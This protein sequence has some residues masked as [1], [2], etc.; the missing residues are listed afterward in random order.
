MGIF[1]KTIFPNGAA[2]AD[3]RLKEGDE[4]LEVNGESLQ[5]LTHQQAIQTF[6]QLKKGV[7]T[8]TV[9]TRLR[10]PSLTPCPTPTLLSRSS[11][12]NSNASGGTPT[13]LPPTFDEPPEARKGPP[14]PG[15]K[16]RIIM[17]VTLNKEPGVG[18]GIGACCLTL[19]NSTPAIY[20]HSLAPGSVAK[21]DGRLSRGDQVLEVDSVSLRHAALS[22][23]YAILSECGPGPVSLIVSRHPNPKVSEQEM[24]E[25]IARSTHRD[26][27]SKDGHSSYTLGL[28]SK[29]PSPTAKAKQGD[30]TSLSW[31]MKRFLEPASRQGSLS[32]EAELSQ[33]FSQEV[34]RHSSLSETPLMGSSDDDM[35]HNQSC[36]TSSDDTP[37][38][39]HGCG[40]GDV[41]C[42]SG[43]LIPSVVSPGSSSVRSP[44]LR[45]RRV[46]CY[47][48]EVS[49]HDDDS[50]VH[51]VTGAGTASRVLADS[52]IVIATSSVEVDE[53]SEGPTTPPY[54]SSLESEEGLGSESPFM[55]IRHS[56]SHQLP[57]AGGGGSSPTTG[58]SNLGLTKDPQ[59][60]VEPRRSPK[61]EHKAVTRVKSMMSI[62]SPPNLPQQSQNQRPKGEESPSC[63]AQGPQLEGGS[64]RPTGLPDSTPPGLCKKGEDCG[65]SPGVCSMDR[66]VLTRREDESFGLDLEIKSS[67][68]KVV[69]TGMRP[70]G[71]ADRESQGRMCVGDE[72]VSIG[73]TPVCS[74]SYHNICEL[75]HNLPITL[76]LQ[77]KRPVS[78]VDRLSSL[79]MSM[80]SCDV[81]GPSRLDQSR[82]PQGAN[83]VASNLG[84]PASSVTTPNP[85]S[86][87]PSNHN[88][89]S[90]IPVTY[91]D[92]IL[93]ELSSSDVQ[94]ALST[95]APKT[96][97]EAQ[98][99]ACA[100][101]VES[102]DLPLT[103]KENSTSQPLPTRP[104]QL[105]IS[106]LDTGNKGCLL[107]LGKTFLNNYSRNFS[108]NLTDEGTNAFLNGVG[109][110]PVPSNLRCNMYNMVEDSDS[111]SEDTITD[112]SHSAATNNQSTQPQDSEEEEV[113]I[114]YNETQSPN[115]LSPH[116]LSLM[117]DVPLS[118]QP[119]ICGSETNNSTK[120]TGP[121]DVI[122][123]SASSPASS[124]AT[125][126]QHNKDWSVSTTAQLD[127]NPSCSQSLPGD[128]SSGA[129]LAVASCHVAFSSEEAD[130][131]SVGIACV[132]VGANPVCDKV[133]SSIAKPGQPCVSVCSTPV[134][135]ASQ[136][137]LP[138]SQERMDRFSALPCMAVGKISNDSQSQT[139]SHSIGTVEA[140]SLTHSNGRLGVS[141][142]SLSSVTTKD[143]EGE[144]VSSKSHVPFGPKTAP[145][146]TS[147]RLR[148]ND[149]IQKTS[150]TAP[151]LKG[152]SIKSKNQEQQL[153]PKTIRAESPSVIRKAKS[154]NSLL[155]S[156]K[157]QAKKS[158][159]AAVSSSRSSKELP[160]SGKQLEW[161]RMSSNGLNLSPKPGG[162][163]QD[164]SYTSTT[165]VSDAKTKPE[166]HSTEEKQATSAVAMPKEHPEPALTTQRTFIEVRLSTSST[167]S[168]PVLTRKETAYSKDYSITH[169]NHTPDIMSHKDQLNASSSGTSLRPGTPAPPGFPGNPEKGNNRARDSAVISIEPLAMGNALTNV[170]YKNSSL[171]DIG[172]E[173]LKA[174]NSKLKAMERRSFSTD[175]CIPTDPKSFSV[176]QRIKSFENL[177]SFDKP[178]L[179]SVEIQ[180][181]AQSYALT[182]AAKPPLN[183]RLSSYV[184]GSVNS[185]D[186]RSLRRS[187][188]SCVDN[189]DPTLTPLS[190]QL[191]KSPS[192]LTLTNFDLLTQ[193]CS[194]NKPP[195]DQTQNKLADREI[196][197]II[198]PGDAPITP[199]TPP[200]LRCKQARGHAHL[201]RSRLRELRALSMPDLDKLCTHDFSSDPGSNATFKTELEIYPT[202]HTEAVKTGDGST[203]AT[204]TGVLSSNASHDD[205]RACLGPIEGKTSQQEAD[206]CNWSISLAVLAGS[207]VE[208]SK[209][210]AVLAS[211]TTKTDVLALIQEA[212]A[213]SEVKDDAYFVVLSKEEGS[214]LGFSIAGGVDLEQK[215][216][217]V[218]RVFSKGVASLEGTI[219]RGDSILSIN[220]VS[221]EGTTHGEALSCLHKSRLSTQALVVIRRGKDGEGQTSP[222]HLTM[223]HRTGRSYSVGCRENVSETD[224][225]AV[226]VGPDGALRVELLKTSAGLGFSLE[227]GK[228]SA[229]GDR[230]L[231]VK[232]VFKG[233]AAELSRVV[234]VGDEVLEV[235]GRSLQGLMHYDAWNIIKTASEGPV[236]LVIRKPRTSV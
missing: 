188:S 134:G 221:L 45:Q 167:S 169:I 4:I 230:P 206:G 26:S 122:Q 83:G 64:G 174:N 214:G 35:L 210:Q 227:G 31:T 112:D 172:V 124:A 203:S 138:Q 135:L 91:I 148:V 195:I 217:I 162:L 211:L 60:P 67:P 33:Y 50:A 145:P 89:S 97:S 70:G 102:K 233:G 57:R 69:I 232:R 119:P 81:T 213:L 152:L 179:K 151:K 181:F 139:P 63:A 224:R 163:A 106:V 160:A 77:V 235:N 43:P 23:A 72:I 198:P 125:L 191:G 209:L 16:D 75:M 95:K 177:A 229:H 215:S 58:H 192:S 21:M 17:E 38:Q 159:N 76:T 154:N 85:K 108:N 82:T 79:M 197:K 226:E 53:E 42:L 37:A 207:P 96:P 90:D 88:H 178:V 117:T 183:R 11:S 92:D 22:E 228:A 186:C 103:E 190:P 170:P 34:T 142:T 78:A 223:S 114:C 46:I 185:V 126:S 5:G 168:T 193:S 205:A 157:L 99:K 158:R 222:R 87:V 130:H 44:L 61:L 202:R 161:N 212:K 171:I 136:N 2:V 220:G 24:V 3:G 10:S 19:E 146:Q 120:V 93:T 189:F 140:K 184:S 8:L 149:S 144:K 98:T 216:V 175:N 182:S 51:L 129:L 20:I 49:D 113:E 234:D 173:S 156:P 127:S 153:S 200:V 141:R 208:Q 66:V 12:P 6:K 180:S 187:F 86:P 201:S 236:Q 231:N 36:N 65:E 204:S 25:V 28:P 18:L 199:Q 54:G 1:V 137:N 30:G 121:F 165:T 39:T 111:E 41:K 116:E 132:V 15:P 40:R 101:T 109:E 219:Q 107:P 155:L 9:R 80:G 62:E 56:D 52:G 131:D 32:S 123:H 100:S 13:P 147:S 133:V 104:S 14:G 115:A 218:H 118:S 47:E 110:R 225:T 166:L 29:S 143:G 48:D 27:L 7:V 59:A 71:A 128:Q 194:T 84:S 73:D 176:R 74:S 94:S 196:P 150:S 164:Q 68:L 105:D 55:P